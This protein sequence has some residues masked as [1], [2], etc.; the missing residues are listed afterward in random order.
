MAMMNSYIS[1]WMPKI[2]SYLAA[3][4]Q[5]LDKRQWKAGVKAAFEAKMDNVRKKQLDTI[6]NISIVGEFS[7][8]KST[9]IN[10]L[11]RYDLLA[12][13]VLQ[14]TT[15]AITMMEYSPEMYIKVKKSDGKAQTYRHKSFGSLR[16]QLQRVTTDPVEG[17][18]VESVVVGLPSPTL[19]KGFRIIDTPGTN[20]TQ[21]WHEDVTR[22]AISEYS[23]MSIIVVDAGRPM[24]QSLCDFVED[25]LMDVISECAFVVTKMDMVRQAERQMLVEYVK[26]KAEECFSIED[27]FVASYTPL[28]VVNQF[29]PGTLRQSDPRLLA[30]T[31]AHENL[32]LEYTGR[33]RAACQAQRVASLTQD[34]YNS[35]SK[36]LA[37]L[38]MELKS[39]SEQLDKTRQAYLEPFIRQEQQE[40]VEAFRQK[41]QRLK[42]AMKRKMNKVAKDT[43]D[44]L[45]GCMA[46]KNNPSEMAKYVESNLKDKCQWGGS[47]VVYAATDTCDKFTA[48]YKTELK[49]F[50]NHFTS[51]FSGLRI[52]NLTIVPRNKVAPAA[53]FKLST[54]FESVV[55]SVKENVRNEN[56]KMGGGALAG[57]AI[58]SAIAPGIGTVIGAVVG[59]FWGTNS[60][61]KDTQMKKDIM[62]NAKASTSKYFDE[63][64][65][66]AMDDVT[67]YSNVVAQCLYNEIDC[68]FREYQ[69]EVARRFEK[70]KAKRLRLDQ[71][72][73]QMQSDMR[74]VDQNRRGVEQLLNDIDRLNDSGK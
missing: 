58:G 56:I 59:L 68:Y 11:L 60:V 61:E 28:E 16:Q 23:D 26:N 54:D 6:L 51:Q 37:A 43:W 12:V 33:M 24:P 9:L 7:S 71:E 64:T 73:V 66:K 29:V 1:G 69:Y 8:G 52:L 53:N 35:L 39:Q 25:N 5:Q 4:R 45:S 34:I 41:V 40:R 67:K 44:N 32:L 65:A 74:A 48:A 70:W 15:V 63:L 3:V 57:A 19:K 31:L 21:L 17:K 2:D 20:S 38:N 27:A 62:D 50:C 47:N 36:E 42:V 46:E 22:H 13:N 49:L 30:D 18:S 10:A 72:I 14:G 55:S